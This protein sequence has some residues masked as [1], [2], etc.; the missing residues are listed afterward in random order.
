M[1]GNATARAGGL[2]DDAVREVKNGNLDK[3]RALIVEGRGV[4]GDDPRFDAALRDWPAFVA[5]H[6]T[7]ED[8]RLL[9]QSV[10]AEGVGDIARALQLAQTAARVNPDNA[11]AWNRVG[12]LLARQKDLPGAAAA[13]GKALELAPEDAAIASNF[14]KIAQLVETSGDLDRGLK[15]LWKKVT[16]G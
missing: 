13:L 10:R 5:A 4:A 9:A 6:K 12:L 15:S 3:A 2:Y 16:R 7:A 8:A 14:T 1:V 11:S